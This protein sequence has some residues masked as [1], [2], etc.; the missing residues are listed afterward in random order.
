MQAIQE[1]FHICVAENKG[2]REEPDCTGDAISSADPVP[3]SEHVFVFDSELGSRSQIGTDSA[4]MR[5]Q[6]SVY[7][8]FLIGLSGVIVKN[9][10]ATSISVENSLSSR[11]SLAH[12]HK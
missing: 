9:I 12:D 11:E 5:S 8:K 1:F 6:H 7:I 3:K 2:Q 10:L 4:Y